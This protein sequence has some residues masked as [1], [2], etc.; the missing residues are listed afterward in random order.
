MVT[1]ADKGGKGVKQMLTIAV[2]EGQFPLP[3]ILNILIRSFWKPCR[4]QY[5]K[6]LNLTNKLSLR[7]IAQQLLLTGREGG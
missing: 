6:L 5:F 3:V 2:Q 4:A 7:T 1:E